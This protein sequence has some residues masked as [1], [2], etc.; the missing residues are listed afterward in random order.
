M[1]V[2]IKHEE[3]NSFVNILLDPV[4]LIIKSTEQTSYVFE[5]NYKLRNQ[6]LGTVSLPVDVEYLEN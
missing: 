4:I 1:P 2:I 5:V 6:Y 3:I